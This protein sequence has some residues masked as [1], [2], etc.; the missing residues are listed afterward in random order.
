M[1]MLYYL[2]K[3]AHFTRIL[4]RVQRRLIITPLFIRSML[5]FLLSRLSLSLLYDV[6]TKMP[7][8]TSIGAKIDAIRVECTRFD[9]SKFH[10]HILS[11]L[12]VKGYARRGVEETSRLTAWIST[13]ECIRPLLNAIFYR[14]Y[15]FLATFDIDISRCL[16]TFSANEIVYINEFIFVSFSWCF[17]VPQKILQR[18]Q[19]QLLIENAFIVKNFYVYFLSFKYFFHFFFRKRSPRIIIYRRFFITRITWFYFRTFYGQ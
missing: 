9:T 8:Y 1:S 2:S 11:K 19:R 15:I 18:C 16:L 3:L 13:P 12:R 14:G 6:G 10:A 7:K 17:A 5:F 4:R